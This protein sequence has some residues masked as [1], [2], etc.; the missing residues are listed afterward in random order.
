MVSK[1]KTFSFVMEIYNIIPI[2]N[3]EVKTYFNLVSFVQILTILKHDYSHINNV[4][5]L[6]CYK[7]VIK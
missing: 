6:P 2:K 7:E 4:K 1:L 3:H 5:F